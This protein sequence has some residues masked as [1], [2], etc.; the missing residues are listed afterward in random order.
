[1]TGIPYVMGAGEDIGPGLSSIADTIGTLLNPDAKFQHAAKLAFLQDPELMQKFVDIEK[2]NP[3]TLKAFGFGDRGSDILS[4]MQESIPA[5]RARM[6]AP[7][8]AEALQTEGPTKR[9]AVSQA[10]TGASPGQVAEDDFSAWFSKEGKKLLDE[11]PDIFIRAARKKFGVGS[12]LDQELEQATLESYKA[13]KP[14]RDTPPMEILNGILSGKLNGREVSGVLTGPEGQGFQAAM[15]LYAINREAQTRMFG[16]QYGTSDPIAR[17]KLAAAIDA[18]QA[19]NGAGSVG[20]WYQHLWGDNTYGA[21]LPGD[22]DAI[23]KTLRDA[24]FN[25]RTQ[26]LQTVFK[27]V[28]PYITA[29]HKGGSESEQKKRIDAIN[30]VLKANDSQ[31]TAFWDEEGWFN[32]GRLG[33]KDKAGNVTSDPTALISEVPPT[34]VQNGRAVFFNKLGPQEKAVATWLGGL[35]LEQQKT[36]AAK[37]RA[38]AKRRGNAESAENILRAAGVE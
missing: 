2:A 21:P 35:S 29:I 31:W 17:A 23:T 16:Y 6:I 38:E 10:A 7:D 27:T 20:G 18:W 14:L 26:Q 33:F 36:E 34:D 30:E 32:F 22:A 9:T 3:G 13:G 15:K 8:V 24:Q 1:M 12:E 19:A 25:K 11:H 28:E 5:I 4:R 37:M